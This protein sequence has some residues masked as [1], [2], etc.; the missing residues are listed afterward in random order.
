MPTRGHEMAGFCMHN[1]FYKLFFLK[2]GEKWPQI[3]FIF[4]YLRPI[5]DASLSSKL[6][7]T[8]QALQISFVG[9]NLRK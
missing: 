2:E 7:N 1:T 9:L 4:K 3:A 5:Y 6:Y 8:Q